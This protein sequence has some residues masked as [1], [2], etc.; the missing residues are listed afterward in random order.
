MSLH[1]NLWQFKSTYDPFSQRVF[2]P[3]GTIEAHGP[4]PV[5]TDNLSAEYIAKRLAEEFSADVLP[6]FPF[7]VNRSLVAHRGSL[8]VSLETFK[9]VVEDVGQA[10]RRNGVKELIVING[11]GGNTQHLKEA[12]HRLHLRHGMRTLGVDWWMLRP[13]LSKEIFGEVQGHGGVEEWAFVV[14]HSPRFYDLLPKKES[15]AAYH[16][17]PGVSVYPAPRSILL[18]MEGRSNS[19]AFSKDQLD[20]YVEGVIEA[21]KDL[22]N[23]VFSGWE[24]IP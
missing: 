24:E 9:A 22:L 19:Y 15:F 5:G 8:G 6:T 11:H 3:I 7:G 10:L 18:Y 23:E 14:A 2:W 20:R 17:R 1:K 4:L 13:E 12:L 16:P 21:L